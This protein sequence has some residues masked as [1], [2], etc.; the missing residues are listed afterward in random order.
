MITEEFHERV[1]SRMQSHFVF[2][3]LPLLP[4]APELRLKEPFIAFFESVAAAAAPTRSSLTGGGG[5]E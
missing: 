4:F 2:P 5:N 3:L 1:Q